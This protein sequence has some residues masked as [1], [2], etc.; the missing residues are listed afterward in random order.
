MELKRFLRHALTPGWLAR[1]RFGQ[2]DLRAIEAAIGAAESGHRGEL[3]FVA[4]GPLHPLDLIASR[5]ARQR[6]EAL[7]G[8][9]RVWDTE[10]NSGILIYVQLVDRKVEIVADRGI[11]ARVAQVEWDALCREMEQAFRQGH[12][13]PGALAAVARAGQLLATHFPARDGD[14]PNEL[15]DAPVL[16]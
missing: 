2:A 13:G 15:P 7:F 5:T 4:E 14:N 6:A 8:L 1:R 11:A 12:Y 16:I 9:L 10:D 3:R